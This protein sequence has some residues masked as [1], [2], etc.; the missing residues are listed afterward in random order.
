MC[1]V[2]VCLGP[3]LYIVILLCVAYYFLVHQSSSS[4]ELCY[5]SNT[6]H[7]CWCII[8]SIAFIPECKRSHNA[9]MN[10][11]LLM[12]VKLLYNFL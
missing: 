8:I 4:A 3:L 6:G 10:F 12:S 11:F 9:H 5:H 1:D 2:Q 7:F